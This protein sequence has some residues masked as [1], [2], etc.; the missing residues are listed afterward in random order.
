MQMTNKHMIRCSTLLI[1]R[2]MQN[3]TRVRFHLSVVRM[4]SVKKKKK[5]MN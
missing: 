2:E 3:K 1:I 4:A 5:K